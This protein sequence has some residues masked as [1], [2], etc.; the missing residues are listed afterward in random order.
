MSDNTSN[1]NKEQRWIGR[2][3]EGIRR[4]RDD[5]NDDCDYT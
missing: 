2:K 1:N 4:E 5:D 3:E